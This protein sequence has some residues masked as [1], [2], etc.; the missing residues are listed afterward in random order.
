M[1]TGAG[2][3]IGPTGAAD[4][5]GVMRGTVLV[6]DDTIFGA[7]QDFK[8]D[9]N[10]E[11][12]ELMDET[13]YTASAVMQSGRKI[14][15]TAKMAYIQLEE[16]MLVRGMTKSALAA[17]VDPVAG[18]TLT[19]GTGTSNFTAGY[20][21]VA[22]SYV[23]AYGETKVSPVTTAQV[24]GATQKIAVTTL[25]ALPSGITSVTWYMTSASYASALLAGAAQLYALVNNAGTAF[26]ITA[27]A[28]TTGKLPPTVSTLGGASTIITA[29]SGTVVQPFNMHAFNANDPT[30]HVYA[31]NITIPNFS[32]EGK[33]G[34]FVTHDLTFNVYGKDD[35]TGS[36][37]RT[38]W[39]MRRIP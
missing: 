19:P 33:I 12:K 9:D 16:F 25:G 14:S 39:E 17:Q 4:W 34:D 13:G 2:K 1:P 24:T 36:G 27:Y 30:W 26:D 21:G 15:V 18:P 7:L 20:V 11:Y 6:P 3:I 28:L 5:R 29:N 10:L 37:A 8:L 32:I 38:P 23:N 22:Y 35:G 31:Y